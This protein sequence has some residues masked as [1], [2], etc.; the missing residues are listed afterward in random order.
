MNKLSDWTWMKGHVTWLEEVS[1]HRN[2]PMVREEFNDSAQMQAWQSMGFTPRTGA[3][4]D[5][6]HADQPDLN[7]QI[8]EYVEKQGLE[9]IGVSYYR[10]DPGDNL[11]YHSDLYSKYISIFDLEKRKKNIV[12]FVFFP[13]HRKPGH[14][15]EVD[16]K[17]IDWKA[18]DWV[19]WKFDTPHLA[20]N[21]GIVSRYS[22][23]VTGVLREDLK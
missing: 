20:A 14:I 17:L 9:H 13:E 4:Y 21:L 19:A 16:G 18:G 11:P 7:K 8:I 12:R 6:R 22:I 15:F 2:L 23:Q 3:L 5:M 1:E 10:M